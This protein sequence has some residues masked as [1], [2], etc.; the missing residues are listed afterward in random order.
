MK[1]L[2]LSLAELNQ[3]MDFEN[4]S[5]LTFSA[6]AVLLCCLRPVV[7]ALLRRYHFCL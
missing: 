7:Y 2:A 5:V 3:G 1:F 4:S 6:L